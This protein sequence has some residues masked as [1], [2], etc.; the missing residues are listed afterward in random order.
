[1]GRLTQMPH[2]SEEVVNMEI[3]IRMSDLIANGTIMNALPPRG[4]IQNR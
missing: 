4:A 2:P 1:M 3:L